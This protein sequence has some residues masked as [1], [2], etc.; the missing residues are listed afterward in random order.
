MQSFTHKETGKTFYYERL[1]VVK[2]KNVA[3]GGT[4]A[5]QQQLTNV[6]ANI[7]HPHIVCQLETEL[8][9]DG[10][11]LLSGSDNFETVTQIG[12]ASCRERV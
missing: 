10:L 5:H 2:G 1:P 8:T 7:A 9:E 4:Q 3:L 12:R 6:D 11:V